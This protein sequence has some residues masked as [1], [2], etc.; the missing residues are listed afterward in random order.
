MRVLFVEDEAII[1][2][3]NTRV[4][5]K[6][7]IDV[8]GAYSGNDALTKG[9]DFDFVITDISLGDMSGYDLIDKFTC[10]VIAMTGHFNKGDDKDE[11]LNAGFYD[12]LPKGNIENIVKTLNTFT[13]SV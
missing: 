9:D 4:M 12:V 5:T 13:Q 7:G 2:F 6:E 1:L 8:V 11:Y 3:Y 10:P